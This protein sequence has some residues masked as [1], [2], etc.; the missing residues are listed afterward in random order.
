MNERG[1]RD[2]NMQFNVIQKLEEISSQEPTHDPEKDAEL[3][4][5]KESLDKLE[6]MNWLRLFW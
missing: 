4:A 2:L 5:V 3:A 6:R 1:K